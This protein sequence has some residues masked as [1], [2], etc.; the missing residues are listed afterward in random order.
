MGDPGGVVVVIDV[1]FSWQNIPETK[2]VGFPML[3]KNEMT[4]H[5]FALA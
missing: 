4:I 3:S 5:S 1:E 2:V